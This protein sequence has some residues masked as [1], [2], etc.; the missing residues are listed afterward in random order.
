MVGSSRDRNRKVWGHRT[1]EFFVGWTDTNVGNIGEVVVVPWSFRAQV[2]RRVV[3]L[4]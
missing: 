3:S 2:T 4:L 1:H